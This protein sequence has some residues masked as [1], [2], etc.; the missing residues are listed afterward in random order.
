MSKP[1]PEVRQFKLAS[2]EEI[3]CEVIQWNNE[4]ELELVVRKA[5][6]LVMGEMETG[7]RYYSFRPW[8]VYQENPDD[9]LVLNGNHVIG[10]AYPPESLISQY[11]EAVDDMSKMWEQRNKEFLQS[12]GD[13]PF[14]NIDS[15]NKMTRQVLEEAS[16]LEEYVEKISSDSDD[17]VIIFPG[18]TD[19]IH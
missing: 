12:R 3:V 15:I 5:M 11:D 9:L 6:K 14:E 13:E 2:G 16:K 10:I 7:V 1:S 8:M 18:P 19:T 4:E 17:N